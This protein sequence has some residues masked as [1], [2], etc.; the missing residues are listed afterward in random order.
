MIREDVSENES[1][2][3]ICNLLLIILYTSVFAFL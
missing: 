3:C 2:I 1:N